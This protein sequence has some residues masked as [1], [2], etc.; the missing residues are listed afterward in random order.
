MASW[1]YKHMN[2]VRLAKLLGKKL[3]TTDCSLIWRTGTLYTWSR[4]FETWLDTTERYTIKPGESLYDLE[5]TLGGI[6]ACI[7]E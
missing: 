5:K 4:V 7:D 1:I 6:V 2:R 3:D